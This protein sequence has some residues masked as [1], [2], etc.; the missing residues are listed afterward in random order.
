VKALAALEK[1]GSSEGAS[2]IHD[3]LPELEPR[4]RDAAFAVLGEIESPDH[5]SRVA[6]LCAP[7]PVTGRGQAG[8]TALLFLLGRRP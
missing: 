1:M 3:A 8:G 2:W 4:L 6:A 7:G 5:L